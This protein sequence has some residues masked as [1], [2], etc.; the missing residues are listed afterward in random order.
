V[1]PQWIPKSPIL[2]VFHQFELNKIS[3]LQS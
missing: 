2:A 3:D 1:N